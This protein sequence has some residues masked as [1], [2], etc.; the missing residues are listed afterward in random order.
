VPGDKFLLG[1]DCTFAVDGSILAGVRSVSVRRRTREV[2]A[3]GYL[4][5]VEST[6]VTHRTYEFD[7]EVLKP[8][9]ADRLRAA[10]SRGTFV[11]VSTSNG[12]RNVSADFVVSE[13]S[14]DEPLDEA[15][16]ARFTLK[17]WAHGK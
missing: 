9:D 8:A 6:V 15:V 3:T 12:L 4:H 1:R 7:V 13:C 11:T 10:E 16:V 14:A 17:Q 2:D 5:N